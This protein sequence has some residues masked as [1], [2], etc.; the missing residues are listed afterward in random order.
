M[1]IRNLE[2]FKFG[3]ITHTCLLREYRLQRKEILLAVMLSLCIF[4]IIISVLPF[5]FPCAFCLAFAEASAIVTAIG[6][7]LLVLLIRREAKVDRRT[8]ARVKGEFLF[9]YIVSALSLSF[10]AIVLLLY[11]LPDIS[12]LK[13]V[14][15]GMAIDSLFFTI[16]ILTVNVI[17]IVRENHE[18]NSVKAQVDQK[19]ANTVGGLLYQLLNLCEISSEKNDVHEVLGEL[20]A[21]HKMILR[22]DIVE[23]LSRSANYH[24]YR[25]GKPYLAERYYNAESYLET[26]RDDKKYL[27]DLKIDYSRFIEAKMTSSI[28]K[29]EDGCDGLTVYFKLVALRTDFS[30]HKEMSEADKLTE[31]ARDLYKHQREAFMA[32]LE[33][34]VNPAVQ[35]ALR[36][37]Q[38]MLEFGLQV[39]IP[40]VPHK[41]DAMERAI[42]WALYDMYPLR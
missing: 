14:L 4:S 5:T 42:D 39:S 23:H 18:G 33:E 27:H 40:F 29:L 11:V 32:F 25:K 37:I 41:K 24:R 12:L 2:A 15:I 22:N 10:S 28:M 30:F 31:Q 1:Q 36:A 9:L 19:M 7:L 34:Y 35:N 38:E 3:Y 16:T 13:E 20:A 8:K 6:S 26:F 17:L 21:S